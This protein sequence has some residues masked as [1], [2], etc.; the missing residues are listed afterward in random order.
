LAH[1]AKGAPIN[2]D[3]NTFD[4]CRRSHSAYFI[5]LRKQDLVLR[6][7]G[8]P[9][10]VELDKA[11]QLLASLPWRIM[12]KRKLNRGMAYRSKG[13][14]NRVSQISLKQSRKSDWW[15]LYSA[16]LLTFTAKHMTRRWK[17]WTES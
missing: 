9:L 17:T 11:I 16:V 3:T 10:E 15:T 6:G 12:P 14:E 13:D 7:S 5:A 1:G 2:L 8:G 4:L